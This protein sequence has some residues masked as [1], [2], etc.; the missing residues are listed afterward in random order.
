MDVLTYYDPALTGGKVT[1]T[2]NGEPATVLFFGTGQINIVMPGDLVPGASVTVQISVGGSILLS[3]TFTV[4]AVD[5][6]LF[7][8]NAEGTGQGA[9]LNQDYTLNSPS[10]PAAAGSFIIVYGTGFGTVSSPGS[11]GLSRVVSG[12]T[13]SVG[14]MPADVTYAGLV[15]GETPGL[16][17][18]NIHLPNNVQ[19]GSAVPIQL[20]DG[21]GST[22]PGVTVAIH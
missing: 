7:T 18:I 6:A 1:V 2:V 14:G 13:A 4:A 16:Q 17:Q 5:P 15:P 20:S 3:S 9:I 22:Q 10:M 11:D 12:V 21:S 19:T 8:D